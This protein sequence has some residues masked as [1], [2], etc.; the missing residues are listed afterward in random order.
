LA[1][2]W[3][4]QSAA[5]LV[6]LLVEICNFTAFFVKVYHTQNNIGFGTLI[7]TVNDII[8]NYLRWFIS[9]KTRGLHGWLY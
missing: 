1:A 8:S 5:V 9:W 6:A 7:I 2:Q 4:D 3:V